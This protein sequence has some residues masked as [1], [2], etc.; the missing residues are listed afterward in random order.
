VSTTVLFNIVIIVLGLIAVWTWW[1]NYRLIPSPAF[2]I[3]ALTMAY[4]TI[5]RVALPVYPWFT[6]YGVAL[7]VYLGMVAS[8]LVLHQTLYRVLRGPRH[9]Q[10]QREI[11]CKKTQA[12]GALD[13]VVMGFMAVI[14]A[15]VLV[16]EVYELWW[17]H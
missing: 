7:P 14:V 1:R 13:Y 3:V 2:I 10:E 9:R 6:A 11:E 5:Y 8:G 12:L 15:V 17:R 16:L 4:L